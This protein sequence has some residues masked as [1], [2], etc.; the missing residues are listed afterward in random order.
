MKKNLINLLTSISKKIIS[1]LLKPFKRERLKIPKLNLQNKEV[2]DKSVMI[3]DIEN[4]SIKYIKNV[5]LENRYQETFQDWIDEK[6]LNV[7]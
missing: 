5:S 2:L 6:S 4:I 1:F 7:A 3:W